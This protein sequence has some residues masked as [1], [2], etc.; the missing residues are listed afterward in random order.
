VSKVTVTL[1][2]LR[3][4]RPSDL[5]VVLVSPDGQ[6][7]LLMS[8]AGGA[9]STTGT[10]VTLTFDDA[11]PLSLTA[12]ALVSGQYKPTNLAGAYDAFAPHANLPAAPVGGYGSSLGAFSGSPAN[13][14]WRLYVMDNAAGPINPGTANGGTWSLTITPRP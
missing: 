10:P 3:H 11:A 8:D 7:V 5:D 6:A 1:N 9:V 4:L 12:A 13:G 2:N 14:S